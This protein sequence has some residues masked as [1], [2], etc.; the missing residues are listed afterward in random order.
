LTISWFAVHVGFGLVHA[1]QGIGQSA[2]CKQTL[3]EL[4]VFPGGKLGVKFQLAT[5]PYRISGQEYG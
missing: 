3:E 2:D 1:D 5:A 4:K